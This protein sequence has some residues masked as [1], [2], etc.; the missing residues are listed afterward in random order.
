MAKQDIQSHKTKQVRNNKGLKIFRRQK[1]QKKKITRIK[2]KANNIIED[3]TQIL[4]EFELFYTD[5]YESKILNE[6]VKEENEN[7]NNKIVNVNSEEMPEIDIEEL[8]KALLQMKNGRAAGEDSILPEML[9]ES[10][11]KTKEELVKLFN[12]C[13]TQECIPDDW[14]NAVV[15]LIYKKGDPSDLKNYRP[16]SLLSQVYKLFIRII[17]NRLE[18]KLEI[19][20]PIE[21]AGFRSHYSTTEHLNSKTTYREGIRI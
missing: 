21:Q 14:G 10:D 3:R 16:I 9:K 1:T 11:R 8:E 2:D 15:I 7:T 18:R 5:L 12:T 13:L 20:Q 17:T 4:R 6:A 19:Y